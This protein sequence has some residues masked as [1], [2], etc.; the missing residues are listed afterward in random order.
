M[1]VWDFVC[2]YTIPEYY[3]YSTILKKYLVWMFYL[4]H[5]GN[6]H[7]KSTCFTKRQHKRHM[8]L[9]T[10]HYRKIIILL[11]SIQKISFVKLLML[12]VKKAFNRKFCFYTYCN[13]CIFY[14]H[15]NY[16]SIASLEKQYTWY[17]C[18]QYLIFLWIIRFQTKPIVPL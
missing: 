10:K 2:D 11:L 16:K 13:I 17:M 14:H 5:I 1:F 7:H 3:L 9:L 4:F 15:H 12:T 8:L 6:F 18:L